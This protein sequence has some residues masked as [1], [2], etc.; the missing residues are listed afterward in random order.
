M[1]VITTPLKRPFELGVLYALLT[2]GLWYDVE[3]SFLFH[4]NRFSTG[5]R[6]NVL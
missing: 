5:I 3:V 2:Y 4:L 1:T 6:R